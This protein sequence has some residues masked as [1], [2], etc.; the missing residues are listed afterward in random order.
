MT[1][2]EEEISRLTRLELA[3][4][5]DRPVPISIEDNR[6]FEQLK[7]SPIEVVVDNRRN[8]Y[9]PELHALVSRLAGQYPDFMDLRVMVSRELAQ[10]GNGF[11]LSVTYD[12]VY[13]GKPHDL[14]FHLSHE[15]P[16][17]PVSHFKGLGKKVADV[18]F[19]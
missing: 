16:E 4:Y 13:I 9:A 3:L 18:R 14:Y 5:A 7:A 10:L 19:I 17:M 12:G 6:L 2:A 8:G 11:A 1:I 15:E